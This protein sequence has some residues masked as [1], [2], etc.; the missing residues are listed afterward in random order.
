MRSLNAP[1]HLIGPLL[2]YFRGAN[3]RGAKILERSLIYGYFFWFGSSFAANFVCVV[4]GEFHLCVDVSYTL[5]KESLVF[6]FCVLWLLITIQHNFLISNWIFT[7]MIGKC[8]YKLQCM[9]LCACCF[10]FY[11]SLNYGLIINY[12]FQSDQNVYVCVCLNTI[13]V[14]FYWLSL[15]PL[16]ADCHGMFW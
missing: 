3:W 16:S 5:V 9:F 8:I 2:A 7:W 12:E 13:N 15:F 14:L 10:T 6:V 11:F 4:V 1:R